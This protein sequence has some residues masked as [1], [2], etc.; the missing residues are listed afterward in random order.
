LR[1]GGPIDEL[2]TK[3]VAGFAASA[4]EAGDTGNEEEERDEEVSIF[5]HV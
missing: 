3:P 5:E 4:V 2:K 1:G